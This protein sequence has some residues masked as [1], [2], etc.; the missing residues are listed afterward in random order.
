MLSTIARSVMPVL[1]PA[2]LALLICTQT[3]HAQRRAGFAP[4]RQASGQNGSTPG[5]TG[6]MGMCQNMGTGSGTGTGS[7]SG[8]GTGTGT[9]TQAATAA[10]AT[11]LQRQLLAQQNALQAQAQY[12]ASQAQVQSAAL[13]QQQRAVARQNAV[14]QL[15]YE[16]QLLGYP[17]DLAIQTAVR[18]ARSSR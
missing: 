1:L 12:Y 8:T 15:A 5:T 2:G 16:L 14:I 4:R 9:I 18:Q 3:A 17:P 10:Q 11:A 7:G 6:Q 13:K